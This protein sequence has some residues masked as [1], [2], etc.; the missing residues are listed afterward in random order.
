MP[1]HAKLSHVQRRYDRSTKDGDT[2]LPYLGFLHHSIQRALWTR[3]I[4]NIDTYLMFKNAQASGA[5]PK[6][7][8]SHQDKR[9]KAH[10]AR[11]SSDVRPGS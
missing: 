8:V 1:S 11:Y 2:P 4:A 6:S 5:S 3:H 9:G 10:W 7:T